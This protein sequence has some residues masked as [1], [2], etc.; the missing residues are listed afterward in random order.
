MIIFSPALVL[1]AASDATIDLNAPVFGYRSAATVATIAATDAATGYPVSNLVNISTDAIWKA[2]DNSGIKYVTI[3]PSPAQELDYVGIARHNFGTAQIA[4]TIEGKET[5]GS[6][7]A[8]L[9]P[10]FMPTNDDSL[11]LRFTKTTYYSV[12]IKLAVGSAPAQAAVVYAGLL[13]VSSQRVYVEH[14]PMTL[15][16]VTEVANG[17]SEKGN[18]LGRVVIGQYLRGALSLTDLKPDWVRSDLVPFI[19]ASKETPFFFAWRPSDYPTETAYCAMTNDPAPTNQRA[20]GM[21]RCDF[22]FEG[23]A[24]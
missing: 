18:F 2:L 6:S 22:E 15:S 13:L 11:I 5:V 24:L 4:V 7:W 8:E 14:A 3:T 9:V 16:P 19:T 20:N 10:E 17:R 12:R 23:V 1:A 21:M